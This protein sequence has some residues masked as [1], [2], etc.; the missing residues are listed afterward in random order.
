MKGSRRMPDSHRWRQL[1]HLPQPGSTP[2]WRT[3]VISSAFALLALAAIGV[4][5][6]LLAS[7]I[8]VAS[9]GGSAVIAFGM[10][11][12]E[13]AQP[14]SL[15]GGHVLSCV[16]GIGVAT[17]FHGSPW[18]GALG[19]GAALAIMQFTGTI[20]SPAGS[21]PLIIVAS[22]GAWLRPMIVL[23]LG[24]ALISLLARASR[25]LTGR[26]LTRPARSRPRDFSLD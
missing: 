17:V 8:V 7:A 13:M 20:H 24:L 11:D 18:A 16:V 14:R 9:L 19:V 21:D 6:S 26:L 1:L 5:H 3:V 4:V 22:N 12:S 15:L 2:D 23:L 25:S 10:P